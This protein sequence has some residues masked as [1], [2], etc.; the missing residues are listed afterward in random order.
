MAEFRM[1]IVRELLLDQVETSQPLVAKLSL[2]FKP[3]TIVEHFQ[4]KTWSTKQKRHRPGC[5]AR[6]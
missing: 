1:T 6:C 5:I 3:K 2:P 4:G